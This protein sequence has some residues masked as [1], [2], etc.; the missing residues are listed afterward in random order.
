[1]LLVKPYSDFGTMREK[2][3]CGCSKS[4]SFVKPLK[5]ELIQWYTRIVIIVFKNLKLVSIQIAASRE[6]QSLESN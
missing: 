3:Q 6:I 5:N 4:T 1:M 2:G